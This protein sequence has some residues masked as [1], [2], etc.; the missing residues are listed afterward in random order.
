MHMEP[1][2]ATL[3]PVLLTSSSEPHL[4]KAL[5]VGNLSMCRFLSVFSLQFLLF[6]AGVLLQTKLA[7]SV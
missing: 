5:G 4:I 3:V 2:C 6:T 7:L 1:E